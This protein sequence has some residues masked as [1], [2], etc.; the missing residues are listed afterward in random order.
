MSLSNRP[1]WTFRA[2][3]RELQFFVVGIAVG[4]IAVCIGWAAS[5]RPETFMFPAL[6]LPIAFLVLGAVRSNNASK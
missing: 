2:N 1:E 4:M 3:P 6:V 5:F